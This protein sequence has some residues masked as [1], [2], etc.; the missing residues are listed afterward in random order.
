MQKLQYISPE[1]Y[2]GKRADS[3]CDN[4]SKLLTKKETVMVSFIV[5]DF[6]YTSSNCA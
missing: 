1:H 2:C 4:D 6:C 5:L 3:H